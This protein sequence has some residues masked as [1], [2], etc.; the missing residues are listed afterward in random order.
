MGES[1]FPNF[2]FKGLETCFD[3][4]YKR[5]LNLGACPQSEYWNHGVLAC[6]GATGLEYGVA[7]EMF[8]R[9]V[10]GTPAPEARSG[11]GSDG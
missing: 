8:R 11:P 2:C 4:R 10:Y 9:G 5:N 1:E 3:L 7:A 6:P